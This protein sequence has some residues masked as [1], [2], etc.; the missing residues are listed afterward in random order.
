MNIE[1]LDAAIAWIE[2]HPEEHDQ[3]SYFART[4]CG[5]TACLAGVVVMLDG[6]VPEW[7]G[8]HW[9]TP[10]ARK[11]DRVMWVRDVA[12]GLLGLS[13]DQ[14]DALFLGAGTLATVKE[15]RDRIAAGELS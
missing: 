11:G 6:W 14:A 3:A 2:E 1:K 8:R 5:T 15:Y 7:A 4:A 12:Q 13:E 9:E 10:R